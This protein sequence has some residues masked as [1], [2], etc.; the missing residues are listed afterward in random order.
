MM[1]MVR[2]TFSSIG[3]RGGE[4]ARSVGSGTADLARRVGGG[5]SSI[6]RQIGPRRALI[7]LAIATVAIGGSILV[8][9]YLRARRERDRLD[10][11]R[12]EDLGAAS[13]IV[14]TDDLSRV[15]DLGARSP[16]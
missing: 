11:E 2:D 14:T 5:T 8:M 9:R 3:D 7:G 6:A 13:R 4:I 12:D 1:N 16:L 15:P 10:F